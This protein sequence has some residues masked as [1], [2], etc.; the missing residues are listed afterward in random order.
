[1]ADRRLLQSTA[2]ALVVVELGVLWAPTPIRVA[3]GLTLGLFLPGF[4]AARLLGRPSMT[5]VERLLLVPG[6]SVATAILTGLCLTA[7]H[8]H[9]TTD[10]WAI[11]LGSVTAVG[12]AILARLERGKHGEKELR[13]DLLLPS[14]SVAPSRPEVSLS[15]L[16]LNEIQRRVDESRRRSDRR[17]GKS[18]KPRRP[19]AFAASLGLILVLAV[20]GA[21]AISAS[22]EHYHGRGFTEL[23]ALHGGSSR[24]T[25]RLGVISHEPHE[26]SYRI[27]VLV[28]GHTLRNEDVA[29]RPGQTWQSI[30]PIIRGRRVDIMLQTSP[31]GP[32]Y[33]RVRL[34]LG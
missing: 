18:D 23:W 27:R 24:S 34:S 28:D 6:M 20:A 15:G 30:Q 7:A 4:V 25:V 1:M 9:M 17:R 14:L 33:R 2:V 21:V 5:G 26:V 29:L 12:V 31:S 22:T 3:A 10:S 32:V 8:I 11:A 13:P 19:Y 16:D